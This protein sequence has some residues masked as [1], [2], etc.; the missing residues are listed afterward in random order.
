[1]GSDPAPTIADLIDR[2]VTDHLPT[3]TA[4]GPYRKTDELRM[5]AEIERRLGK[6]TKVADVHDG[7][8]RKMHA[9][10]TASGRRVRANRI[11]AM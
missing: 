7:D 10:I 1:V 6:H 2:Y 4:S 5:L 11:R 9:D 3:K 8:I